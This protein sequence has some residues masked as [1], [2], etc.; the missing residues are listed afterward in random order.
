M[1]RMMEMM[2]RMIQ[3]VKKFYLEPEDL[4]PLS[5]NLCHSAPK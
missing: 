3:W 5:D 4:S 2:G 1:G